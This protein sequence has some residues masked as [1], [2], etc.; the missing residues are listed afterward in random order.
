MLKLISNQSLKYFKYAFLLT[1][2]I[3]IMYFIYCIYEMKNLQNKFDS[4]DL[5]ISRLELIQIWGTPDEE[6]D[7]NQ[8]YDKRH[9]LIYNDFY[10][11]YIF[12]S[13]NNRDFITEKFY[14]D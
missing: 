3:L 4:T 8:E 6:F 13:K 9:I 1:V 10:G 7:M 12:A 2:V 14:D 5:K 11:R